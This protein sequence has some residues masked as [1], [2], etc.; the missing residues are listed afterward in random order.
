LIGGFEVECTDGSHRLNAIE[1]DKLVTKGDIPKLTITEPDITDKSKSDWLSK[2]IACVQVLW[3]ALQLI[4]RG[5]QHLPATPLEFFTLGIV[6]CTLCTYA[7]FWYAPQDIK[8]PVF[9]LTGKTLGE[10]FTQ[11]FSPRSHTPF[12]N[13]VRPCP[14]AG[15]E[16][17]GIV[18]LVGI[19]T[20]LFGACHVIAWDFP[21]PSF[22]E[23]LLWR[24]SSLVCIVLPMVL[25]LLGTRQES[26]AWDWVISSTGL[27]YILVRLF[28]LV[29]V[30]ASFRSVPAGVYQ[31]VKIGHSTFHTCK[32]EN[33]SS[34]SWPL[35]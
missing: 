24:V 2:S 11:S 27:V 10:F 31:T 28:L 1:F 16:E 9:I 8:Q 21:F 33:A 29:E 14:S 30:F 20:S 23:K 22:V 12:W 34:Y 26:S 25:L 6:V 15:I 32:L 18:I 3:L 13:P 5:V 17:L 19:V 7:A 35:N 4:A